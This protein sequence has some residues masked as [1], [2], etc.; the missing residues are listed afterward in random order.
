MDEPRSHNIEGDPSPFYV[1]EL[2]VDFCL[3][4][5]Q[6]DY[7][8]EAIGPKDSLEAMSM[9]DS[10]ALKGLEPGASLYCGPDL[11]DWLRNRIASYL[12]DVPFRNQVGVRLDDELNA[13]GLGHLTGLK[14]GMKAKV[15][16]YICVCEV[17][18]TDHKISGRNT[19]KISRQAEQVK[20]RTT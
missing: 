2:F 3:R 13:I 19:R 15:T 18:V 20:G 5:K 9:L 8:S 17:V 14:T 16:I 4:D 11:L 7:F 6:E 10:G 12:Q 1:K